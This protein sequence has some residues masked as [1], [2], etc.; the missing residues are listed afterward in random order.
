MNHDMRLR[1]DYF[2]DYQKKAHTESQDLI[3]TPKQIY[4]EPPNQRD[5]TVTVN[6]KG[7]FKYLS[8]V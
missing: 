5:C 2:S 3:F 7:P 6:L 1:S 8:F 4:V